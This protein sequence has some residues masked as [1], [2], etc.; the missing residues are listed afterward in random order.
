MERFALGIIPARGGSKGIKDKNI[1]PLSGRPLI[2]YTIE[3]AK[4]SKMLSDVI[5]STD[6]P[7]IARIAISEGGHVPFLRPKEL[8]SDE[9][10]TIE[11]VKHAISEYEKQKKCQIDLVVILQPTTPLRAADDIDRAVHLFLSAPG[12]DSLISCY[13]AASVHPSIMYKRRGDSLRPFME[14]GNSIKRRQEFEP[15]Y[16]R[17][18]AIYV[19]SREL[20]LEKNRIIGNRPLGYIMPR[21]RSINIDEALDLEITEFLIR[22][23]HEKKRK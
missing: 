12:A 10:P 7:R 22:R 6:S 17:N 23:R 21:E 11:T 19:A 13:S 5:I 9:S 18:G 1:S 3:T 16:V 4:K 2:A 20:V 15:L 8:A 14:A